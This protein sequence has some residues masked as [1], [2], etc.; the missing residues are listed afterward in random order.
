MKNYIKDIG[1]E[2]EG[3]IPCSVADEHCPNDYDDYHL[4]SMVKKFNIPHKERIGGYEGISS[5]CD[6]KVGFEWLY[7]GQPKEISQFLDVMFNKLD[8][9]AHSG[10]GFHMHI[11]FNKKKHYNYA[12][13]RYFWDALKAEYRKRYRGNR[14]FLGRLNGQWSKLDYSMLCGNTKGVGINVESI[15]DNNTLEI[16]IMP[17]QKS[18]K[19]AM[20]SVKF[21]HNTVNK[22]VAQM[23]RKKEFMKDSKRIAEEFGYDDL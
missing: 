8:Y 3:Q 11:K 1:I 17:Y 15:D 16:R 19:E 4:V 13:N 23:D 10:C 9:N 7:Y 5:S 20:Q 14:R 2:L 22:I 21:I 12:F 18:R 6:S